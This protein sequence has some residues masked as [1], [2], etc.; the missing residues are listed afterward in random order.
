MVFV[1]NTGV[2]FDQMTRAIDF[3]EK[4]AVILT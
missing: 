3:V 2:I 4:E 1:E